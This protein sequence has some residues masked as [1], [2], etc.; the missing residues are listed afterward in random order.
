MML[1][2]KGQVGNGKRCCW[3]RKCKFDYLQDVS[4]KDRAILKCCK[5]ML[6]KTRKRMGEARIKKS[7]RVQKM[8]LRKKEQVVAFTR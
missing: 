2:K 7:L 5:T 8:M 4:G 1:G 6:G 3:E